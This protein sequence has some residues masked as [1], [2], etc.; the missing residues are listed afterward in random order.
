AARELRR[1][2]ARVSSRARRGGGSGELTA[3]ER[4]IAE[5]VA[6]GRSNKQVAAALFVSEKTVE[7]HLSA[8]YARLG[9]RSRVE[10]P[11]ALEEARGSD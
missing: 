10:L 7:R 11:R 2:G 1:A 9:I 4:E 8:I 3:R 6:G 5:L